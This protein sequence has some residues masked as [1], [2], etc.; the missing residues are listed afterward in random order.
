MNY[1]IGS[2][3]EANHKSNEHTQRDSLPLRH[4]VIFTASKFLYLSAVLFNSG[5]CKTVILNF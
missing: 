5:V 2:H 3:V 4:T 1:S